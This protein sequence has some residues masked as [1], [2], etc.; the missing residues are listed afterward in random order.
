MYGKAQTIQQITFSVVVLRFRV[1]CAA[2]HTSLQIKRSAI[3]TA[4]R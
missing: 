1:M 2:A 3:I 4:M